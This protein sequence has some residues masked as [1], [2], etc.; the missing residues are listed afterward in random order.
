MRKVFVI[1]IICVGG[2]GVKLVSL[3]VFSNYVLLLTVKATVTS[4][5]TALQRKSFLNQKQAKMV[6]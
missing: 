5:M 2:L 1:C 6:V 3:Y 4:V